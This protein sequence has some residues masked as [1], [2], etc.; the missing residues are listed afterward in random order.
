MPYQSTITPVSGMT[1]DHYHITDGS[2]EGYLQQYANYA[3][4]AGFEE[5]LCTSLLRGETWGGVWREWVAGSKR[6]GE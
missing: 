3:N 1:S 4:E 5:A 6:T 2:S